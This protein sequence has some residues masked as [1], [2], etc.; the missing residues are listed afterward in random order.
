MMPVTHHSNLSFNFTSWGVVFS[1]LVLAGTVW[2][3]WTGW[4]RNPRPLTFVLECLR[5]L[6]VAVV[7]FLLAR[8]E[9]VTSYVSGRQ[10]EVVVLWDDSQSMTTQDVE[11]GKTSLIGRN[12]QVRE[13]LDSRFWEPLEEKNKVRVISFSSPEKTPSGEISPMSGTDIAKALENVLAQSGNLRT[14]VLLSDGD[15]TSGKPPASL[16]QKYRNKWVPI[17]TVPIGSEVSLPDIA[18]EGVRAPAYGIVGESVQIPFSIR[19]T[20]GREVNTTVTL[21]SESGETRTK[22]I[23]LPAYGDF[24]D[25]ILWRINR[26]GDDKLELFVPVLPGERA[27]KNNRVVFPLSG[28]RESIQVLVIDSEPRWEYRFIR[29]ALFRDP[30]VTVHTLLFHPSLQTMGQGEGYLNKFPEKLEDLSKYDVI[31]IGDV[32]MGRNGLTEKQAE[33]LKG[34][35]ESQAS[36]VVFLPGSRGNQESLVKGPLGDLMPVILQEGQK[37]GVTESTPSPLLLTPEG[38]TSL[39]TSLANSEA[40]NAEVWRSLPGFYWHAPVERAKAGSLV[41]ATHPTKRNRY[42]KIPLLVTKMSGAGKVLYMGTDSAWRWRKGVEDLY[43]YRFWGQVARWMSYQRNMAAGDRIRVYPDQ[44][45]PGVGAS[46]LLTAAVADSHGAPL[47]DG[48]VVAEATAPDGS[49][50]ETIELKSDGTTW[51]VYT[52]YL[53]IDRPGEWKLKVYNVEEPDK[54]VTLTLYTAG[55]TVE[56]VGRVARPDLLKELADISR[57][58]QVRVEELNSLVQDITLLPAPRPVEVR[59]LLWCHWLSGAFLLGLMCLF[60]VGRKWNGTV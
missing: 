57:G 12:E 56:K 42:G 13:I 39:L 58:R 40:E 34:L 5:L 25:T 36:G 52:G 47:K 49:L 1:L 27:E 31:F 19:N 23:K 60:W 3:C 20:L 24:T 9:W 43:H 48:K 7:L 50:R 37:E 11:R 54:A 32:G 59:Y 46:V 18:V 55:E 21:R 22:D 41:L 26:E 8:P 44:E 28:R 33:L 30:G 10:P 51:G 16:A 45:R 15:N 35:V 6:I 14:V 4:K 29:N 53:K 17:Y 2:L 38:R